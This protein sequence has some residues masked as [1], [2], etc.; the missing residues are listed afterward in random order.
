MHV[1][2]ALP[3]RGFTV[4]TAIVA[5]ASL[6]TLCLVA[7]PA[8]AQT[9]TEK[10]NAAMAEDMTRMTRTQE[11]SKMPGTAM[12]NGEVALPEGFREWVFIGAPLTPNGL[13]G[14]AAA[15]PE[16]HHVYIEPIA[17]A[18]YEKTGVFPEGT[19]I[20]KELVTLKSPEYDDGSRDEASGRGFFAGEFG[21]IDMM[22][23]DTQRYAA[24]DGWGFFNYGH[25][26]PP[27]QKTAAAL[28]AENCSGCH[29]ANAD[30]DMVFT[31]FYPILR[32]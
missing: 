25:H 7:L 13:N 19:V 8:R 22:V 12:E 3:P 17:Y 32:K 4:G 27:Y 23:K 28:P 6:L 11:M 18:A 5:A 20:V 9:M 29:T 15:F 2:P 31:G 1:R 30:E 14:G 10:G 24:T 21:G 26:K 16:F